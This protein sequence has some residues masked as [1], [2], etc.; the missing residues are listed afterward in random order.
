MIEITPAQPSSREAALGP[1]NTAIKLG[2]SIRALAAAPM[3]LFRVYGVLI[4]TGDAAIYPRP[5]DAERGT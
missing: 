5:I 1:I 3:G 4:R 2:G